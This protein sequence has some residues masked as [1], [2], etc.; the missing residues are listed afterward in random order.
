VRVAGTGT[1][2]GGMR[3]VGR[4]R[5]KTEEDVF[6]PLTEEWKSACGERAGNEKRGR[7]D[8]CVLVVDAAGLS[9]E[10]R[11]APCE[12]LRWGPLVVT[13]IPSPS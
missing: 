10:E 1:I 13:T 4:D 7:A 3:V 6:G 5:E 12:H 9:R 11:T 2:R 8:G